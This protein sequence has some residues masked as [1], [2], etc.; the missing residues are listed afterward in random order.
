MRSN[1]VSA[2]YSVVLFKLPEEQPEPVVTFFPAAEV[3]ERLTSPPT[4]VYPPMLCRCS[5][6][7]VPAPT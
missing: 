3:G 5:G 7:V 6:A 2:D 4:V 1:S